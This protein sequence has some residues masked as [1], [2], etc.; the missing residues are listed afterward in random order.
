MKIVDEK[1]KL[2]GIINIIDLIVLLIFV[3][4]IGGGVKRMK[5]NPAAIAETKKAIITIE[6][7]DIRTPT[8]E[9]I[10]IGDPLYHYDKGEKIGE[11]V[12]KKVEPYKE[13]AENADG[14]WV[15]SEVPGKYVVLM[16]VEADVKENPDVVI[17]GG[18]QIRIGTQFKLKNKNVAVLGTILGV[19]VQ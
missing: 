4:L 10:V 16:T 5:K 19:E 11:I 9:G 1:G 12:D 3:L 2:F 15:L 8:V 13:P 7:A 18:E 6:V 14:K 17:A